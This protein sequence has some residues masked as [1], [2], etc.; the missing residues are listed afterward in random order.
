MRMGTRNSRLIVVC[1]AAAVGAAVCAGISLAAKWGLTNVATPNP[2]VVGFNEPNI[3]SPELQEVIWAQGSMK[4]E[5]GTAAFPYYGYDGN[6]PQIPPFVAAGPASN[7][8]AT[9]TE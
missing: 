9:K 1:A 8:E 3:L 2:K 7:V 5:N 6:G 4:I